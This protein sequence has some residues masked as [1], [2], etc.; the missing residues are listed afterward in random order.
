MLFLSAVMFAVACGSLAA[1]WNLQ[2]R[3]QGLQEETDRL[4]ESVRRRRPAAISLPQANQASRLDALQIEISGL[5]TAAAPGAQ[6]SSPEA[7]IAFLR[8][9]IETH[10]AANAEYQAHAKQV[11]GELLETRR[12]LEEAS[13]ALQQLRIRR[14]ASEA[15]LSRLEEAL[16][17]AMAERDALLW[18]LRNLEPAHNKAA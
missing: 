6:P 16:A 7:C 10:R 5:V 14:G 4:R 11:S 2:R 13:A 18:Q 12:R 8:E 15:Q 9:V 1:L 17:G 3:L